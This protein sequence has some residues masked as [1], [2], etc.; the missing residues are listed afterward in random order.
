[1]SAVSHCQLLV[2]SKSMP[3]LEHFIKQVP[4]F[5][6]LPMTL[7]LKCLFVC[8]YIC[9]CNVSYGS[10]L[11]PVDLVEL[12]YCTFLLL[13]NKDLAGEQGVILWRTL[14]MSCLF[15]ILSCLVQFMK[16]SVFRVVRKTTV[17]F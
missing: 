9:R 7:L 11:L 2:C 6:S 14:A 13:D 10:V 12:S 17:T 4:F 1:M 5:I 3:V 16:A 15:E 8:I